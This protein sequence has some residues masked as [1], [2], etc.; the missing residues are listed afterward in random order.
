M[1]GEGGGR[2]GGS[3]GAGRCL[4]EGR[5]KSHPASMTA[6]KRQRKEC[7]WT[8]RWQLQLEWRSW[9]GGHQA[10]LAGHQGACHE[11]KGRKMQCW[12]PVKG[13]LMEQDLKKNQWLLLLLLT[14][15]PSMQLHNPRPYALCCTEDCDGSIRRRRQRERHASCGVQLIAQ[16]EGNNTAKQ[17]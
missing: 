10:W 17:Y 11:W 14:G 2:G 15:T 16:A 9:L 13:G 8:R 5:C 12:C 4:P 6:E 3:G 7:W 1:R